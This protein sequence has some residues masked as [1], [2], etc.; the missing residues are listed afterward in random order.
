MKFAFAALI[1]GGAAVGTPTG[2]DAVTSVPGGVTADSDSVWFWFASCGG[3]VIT[4]EVRFDRHMLSQ[5]TTPLCKAPRT[6]AFQGGEQGAVSFVFGPG[7]SIVWKGYRS[8]HDTTRANERITGGI[9][10]TGAD[11][12]AVLLGVS[13]S[14]RSRIAM[15]TIHIAHPA[16]ADTTEIA[17]GLFVITYP[18]KPRR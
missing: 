18:G 15:N 4:V 12:D 13:F 3:P 8:N 17:R 9:W 10:E 11:S 2:S 14:V 5:T 16:K 1:I 7:R 6:S